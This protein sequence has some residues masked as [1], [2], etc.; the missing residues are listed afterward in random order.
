MIDQIKIFL[1]QPNPSP[2]TGNEESTMSRMPTVED[3]ARLAGVSR[4]TV[5]NVLNTPAIVREA[6]RHRVEVAI[7]DLG[8]R[9]HASARR[10]RT[11]KAG[12][13]GM[14]IDPWRDG[15]SGAVLDRLLH[16]LTE[17]AESRGM[18]VM[19]FSAEDHAHEV[20][21]IRRLRE[22][23]DVD[24]F[25]LTATTHDDPRIGA[26]SQM[27]VPFVAFGRPWGAAA[28][29][30]PHRWIDVDG[31]SGVAEAVRRL[32]EGGARR[33]A[34]I[35]WPQGSGTGDERA[36]GWRSASGLDDREAQLL[37]RSAEDGVAAGTRCAA[38]LL[39]L[40]DPPDA[41]VCASDS[42]ALGALIAVQGT[43][44]PETCV[45]GFDDTPVAAAVGLSSIEQPLDGVVAAAL[46]LLFGPE[47]DDVLPNPDSN[48][49]PTHR[50]LVPQL[51]ERTPGQLTFDATPAV[52]A[53]N[54]MKG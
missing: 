34:W 26:L 1:D 42:L 4:Q 38:E 9:P 49:E 39:R 17:R 21:V 37:S 3:V 41:I 23:S 47:G 50:L 19:V 43:A 45:V 44:R 11:R 32:R 27:G 35:G 36:A 13:I 24:A 28:G 48:E 20:E 54:H 10:L 53:G 40:A 52:D 18:R 8:Y 2:Q 25:M 6:T 30:T 16:K 5:S 31:R 7:R 15:I 51:V 14:R 29:R 33:I 12:T 46:E 22:G